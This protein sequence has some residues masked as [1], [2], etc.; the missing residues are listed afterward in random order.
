M[1]FELGSDR[2]GFGDFFGC[3]AAAF[4]HV[5]KIGISAHIELVGVIYRHTAVEKEI[6]ESAMHDCCSDLRLDIIADD[7]DACFFESGCPGWIGSDKDR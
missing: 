3:E 5:L 2:A 6:G 1:E 4:K 7:G